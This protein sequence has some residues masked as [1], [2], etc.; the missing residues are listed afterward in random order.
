MKASSSMSLR[1]NALGKHTKASSNPSA[2][3]SSTS[4][5]S[6]DCENRI[7]GTFRTSKRSFAVAR[8]ARSS[9]PSTIAFL[10]YGVYNQSGTACRRYCLCVIR[11]AFLHAGRIRCRRVRSR[12]NVH[13]NAASRIHEGEVSNQLRSSHSR[14]DGEVIFDAVLPLGGES[15]CWLRYTLHRLSI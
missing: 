9:V 11:Y 2:I 6:L 4:E 5:R 7:L 14:S 10:R 12:V 8:S 1:T 13:R 3:M 15:V